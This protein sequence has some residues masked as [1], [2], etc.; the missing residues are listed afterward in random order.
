MTEIN[1]KKN[2][3]LS[4]LKGLTYREFKSILRM[5]ETEVENTSTIN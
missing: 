2:E 1:K 3:I 4:I 5:L